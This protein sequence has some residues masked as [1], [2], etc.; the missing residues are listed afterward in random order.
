MCSHL[1]MNIKP[2]PCFLAW[3]IAHFLS[4]PSLAF[5]YSFSILA[6]ASFSQCLSLSVSLLPYLLNWTQATS[7]CF[8]HYSHHSGQIAL[9]FRTIGL[10]SC[11]QSF[12]HFRAVSGQRWDQEMDSILQ[13]IIQPQ[14]TDD[15]VL[16]TA[17]SDP[18]IKERVNKCSQEEL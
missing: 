3:V 4:L 18:F 13:Q 14:A 2:I 5:L 6:S 8:S 17:H 11:N 9:S 15:C 1:N 12:P 16:H 10:C 7:R